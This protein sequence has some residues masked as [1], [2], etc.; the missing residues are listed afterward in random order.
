MIDIISQLKE[1]KTT[2]LPLSDNEVVDKLLAAELP[3]FLWGCG[4]YAEYIY[5]ILSKNKIAIDEVFIDDDSKSGLEF[6]G[7]KV[8]SF[9]EIESKYP[10]INIIRG[11]GNIEQE[12]RFMLMPTV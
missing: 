12:A 11:N 7:H 1:E 9:K 10:R 2:D 6:H 8:V 5:G 3:L 4:N